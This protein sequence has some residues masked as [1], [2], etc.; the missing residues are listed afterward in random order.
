MELNAYKRGRDY[1]IM[2]YG[3]EY[4]INMPDEIIPVVMPF[5]EKKAVK[6]N[7]K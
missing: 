1:F 3:I 6:K 2:L 5:V 7:K 4:K